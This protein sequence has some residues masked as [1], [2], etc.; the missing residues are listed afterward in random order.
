M[1]QE[2]SILIDL[3]TQK[4]FAR[5]DGKILFS[6]DIS[7]GMYGFSTPTGTFKVLEKDKVHFSTEYPKRENGKDGGAPMPY[8]MKIT[9]GGVAIHEGMIRKENN[10]AIPM[11][12]GC[13]RVPKKTVKKLFTW[14]SLQTKVIIK[15]QTNYKDS[16]NRRYKKEDA[17]YNRIPVRYSDEYG[18][19]SEDSDDNGPLVYDESFEDSSYF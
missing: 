14:A 17:E 3:D 18:D 19:W 6:S 9:K 11:S 10:V 12:H 16:I 8:T 4:L 15:G 5:E 1:A 2:K 7:S 13:I